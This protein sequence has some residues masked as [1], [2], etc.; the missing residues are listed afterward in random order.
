[1]IKDQIFQPKSGFQPVQNIQE[2]NK[3]EKNRTKKQRKT[4]Q[5]KALVMVLHGWFLINI[6]YSSLFSSTSEHSAFTTA[7]LCNNNHC[8]FLQFLFHKVLVF[9]ECEDSRDPT[10]WEADSAR[11]EPSSCQTGISSVTKRWKPE[12]PMHCWLLPC[13]ILLSASAVFLLITNLILKED[14]L[15]FDLLI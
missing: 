14:S 5:R 8:D 15:H 12:T 2:F 4:E 6:T 11:W 1:M 3:K 13:F 7:K 9:T 10:E